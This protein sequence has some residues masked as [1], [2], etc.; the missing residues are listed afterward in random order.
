MGQP[1]SFM[2]KRV[3][4]SVT[5]PSDTNIYAINDAL[6]DATSGGVALKLKGFALDGMKGMYLDRAEARSSANQSTLPG[7]ALHLFRAAIASD[8][9]DNAAVALTDAEAA[10]RVGVIEFPAA[11]WK[12]LNAASGASGNASCE[13]DALAKLIEFRAGGGSN[14]DG[15]ILY[16]VPVLLNT[17]T[18]VSGEIFT[19]DLELIPNV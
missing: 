19:F 17:Y 13:K 10:T 6:S 3:T 2:Q 16:A 5:R 15:E 8:V 11:D 12:P 18:P 4:V 9:N 7:I 1:L 14:Q